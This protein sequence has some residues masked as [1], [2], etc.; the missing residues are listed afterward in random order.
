[1]N[2]GYFLVK[3]VQIILTKKGNATANS[4]VQEKLFKDKSYRKNK[5][6]HF[7]MKHKTQKSRIFTEIFCHKLY[8][9]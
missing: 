9:L 7:G 2:T 1:M 4:T 5:A 8:R 6:W 3:N